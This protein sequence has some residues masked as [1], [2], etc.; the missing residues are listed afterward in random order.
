[1]RWKTI[2]NSH[3]LQFLYSLVIC[4]FLVTTLSSFVVFLL[5]RV[6][7]FFF[8]MV[9]GKIRY[10]S[11]DD[12]TKKLYFR[13]FFNEVANK[14]IQNLVSV[15]FVYLMSLLCQALQAED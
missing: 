1:M 3:S 2:F 7:L 11:V 14:A 4:Y 6:I 9:C 8:A 12:F 13:S 15:V 5:P 10:L